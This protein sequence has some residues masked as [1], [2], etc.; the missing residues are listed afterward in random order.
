[1]SPNTTEVYGAL[2]FG[3]GHGEVLAQRDQPV[4]LRDSKNSGYL[5]LSASFDVGGG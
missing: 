3:A 5:D 4:R 2:T 1:V